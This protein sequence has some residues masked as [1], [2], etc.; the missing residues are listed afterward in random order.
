MFAKKCIA[1]LCA[2]ASLL[3]L[4]ALAW[5]HQGHMLVGAIADQLLTPQAQAGLQRD[6]GLTLAQ[7]APWADC[8]KGVGLGTRG[9][10]YAADE[11]WPS[12]ACTR[13]ETAEGVKAMQSYASRNWNTCGQTR[14][15]HK[16]YHYADVAYAHGRYKMGYVGT[17]DHD[18]VHAINAAIAEL[19]GQP[20]P[21]P[22]S[23]T[24]RGEALRMLA[25][26]IGDLH[27]PLHVGALYL[28]AAGNTVDPDAPGSTEVLETRG[29]NSIDTGHGNN[30]H[31][32]WD[33][34]PDGLRA[35]AVPASMLQ[36]ARALRK[37]RAGV[38]RLAQTWASDTVAVSGAAFAGLSLGPANMDKGSRVWPA[39]FVDP[40][41][42][43]ARQNALQRAQLTKA[44]ARLAQLVNAL[45]A[46]PR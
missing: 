6:M 34:I 11:R 32:L 24:S 15:C 37:S 3:P 42:Y 45:Y 12:P 1:A 18:L 7:A 31:A 10:E 25:H 27:Q 39:T 13:F 22:F 41:D 17:N 5:G 46:V 36:A 33:D 20:V 8:A 4:P 40:A 9:F 29:G 30:L 35:D 28:D 16:T 19:Q 38:G 26:F 14:D 2:A 44:G 21:P 43:R 23:I